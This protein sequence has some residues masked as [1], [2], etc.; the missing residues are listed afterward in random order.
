VKQGHFS[1]DLHADILNEVDPDFGSH[2]AFKIAEQ[3]G[4]DHARHNQ[5]TNKEKGILLIR[6]SNDVF[7]R[8]L[9]NDQQDA[10]LFVCA[11]IVA[12]VILANLFRYFERMMATKIRVDLVRISAWR[13]SEKCPCFTSD[14]LTPNV[15][16]ILSPD[17]QTM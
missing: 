16:G 14:I 10:L 2:H 13:S 4:Q 9:D 1:E 5:R 3:I 15:K 11:L 6:S 12:C 7:L 8:S 17:S